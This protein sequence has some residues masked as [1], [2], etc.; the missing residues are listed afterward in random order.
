[1]NRGDVPGYEFE[2]PRGPRHASGPRHALDHDS[3]R[4]L[5][6]VPA[7]EE[8]RSSVR[9]ASSGVLDVMRNKNW[10][11]GLAAPILAAIAVGIAVVVIAGGG[12]GAGAAPSALAAG[13]PPA[14]PAG[15][16]FAGSRV[17][18]TAIGADAGTE[19][20]AGGVN[21]GPALWD[22]SDGGTDWTRAVLQGPAALTRAGAGQL[23]EVAHGPAGWLAVGTT[24]AG[25]GGPLVASS[26]TGST[27]TVTSGIAGSG[28][29]YTATGVAAGPAAYVIVGR[30]SV[31]HSGTTAATAWYSPGLTGWRRATISQLGTVG[32]TAMMNGVTATSAGF[33]AVGTMGTGP[34]A[35]LSATGQ[36][37][38]QVAVPAPA[39]SARAA[40]DYV[41]ANGN[42]LVAAGTEFSAAG[43]SY[44]FAEV[45]ADA[46]TTWTQ[47]QLPVPVTGPGTGTTVT[48][49]TAAGGGFTA[50]GTYVTRAGPE[51]VIWTL[52][53]GAQGAAAAAWTAVS[54]QGV[55]LASGTTENAITALTADGATLTGVGFTAKLT[56]PDTAGAEE[57][58]LWQSPIRY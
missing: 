17:I 13:F 3:M 11:V 1:M 36:A 55:G 2:V 43:A 10:L 42:D 41:A 31:G 18:L 45:S 47:V 34:A 4:H 28:A 26:P 33:V 27:W 5:Q 46:G 56:S 14:R 53:P 35:W 30:Q 38:R 20:T 16:G 32:G 57:P 9:A 44:P 39:N 22:S 49:L 25:T 48:A 29:G 58:T 7:E 24:I 50:V 54:P 15:A 6:R 51:V 37:W 21:G 8:S 52:P 19:V 40:L 12:G 23:A